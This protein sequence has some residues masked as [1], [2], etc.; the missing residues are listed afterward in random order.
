M[1]KQGT[2]RATPLHVSR[3]GTNL[4]SRL[5]PHLTPTP[6]HLYNSA[7][8]IS[9]YCACLPASCT[10]FG[11]VASMSGGPWKLGEWEWESLAALLSTLCHV[12]SG[13]AEAGWGR[14]SSP[15]SCT[16]QGLQGWHTGL[17]AT[18][19]GKRNTRETRAGLQIGEGLPLFCLPITF[20]CCCHPVTWAVLSQSVLNPSSV[21]WC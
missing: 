11:E 15:P 6:T 3:Q 19:K 1:E 17:K 4:L 18:S 20:P 21:L 8:K 16:L 9:K 5:I 10:H 14:T 7:V 12:L 13:E 2:C